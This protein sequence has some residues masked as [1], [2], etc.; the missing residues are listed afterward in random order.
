VASLIVSCYVEFGGYFW[1]VCSF[2]KGK[3]RRVDLGERGGEFAF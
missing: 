2:L 1:E 3:G